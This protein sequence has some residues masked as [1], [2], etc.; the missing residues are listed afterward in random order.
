MGNTKGYY[1]PRALTSAPKTL[2]VVYTDGMALRNGQADASG[3]V[4]VYFGPGDSRNISEPLKGAR[5]T[6]QRA[7][8]E[9]IKRA[10][11]ST[12]RNVPLRVRTDSSYAVG[13]LSDWGDRWESNGWTNSRGQPVAN[14]DLFKEIGGLVKERTA[15]TTFEHVYAHRGSYGNQQAGNLA[16]RG[17]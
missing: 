4:G 5:Q 12:P 10:V 9:A 14:K 17:A 2:Q 7:G 11:E 16:R 15:P 13:G 8:L 1:R 6:N 3:G